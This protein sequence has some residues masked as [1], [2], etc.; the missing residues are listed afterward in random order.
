ML[1]EKGRIEY[2]TPAG[3]YFTSRLRTI[4]NES[5]RYATRFEY[6]IQ[7]CHCRQSQQ[8]RPCT[9]YG[10]YLNA[11]RL[12]EAEPCC[13]LVLITSAGVCRWRRLYSEGNSA[14]GVHSLEVDYGQTN[15]SWSNRALQSF[16]L[17]CVALICIILSVCLHKRHTLF[18]WW[19]CHCMSTGMFETYSLLYVFYLST[20]TEAP[21]PLNWASGCCAGRQEGSLL[22]WFDARMRVIK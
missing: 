4:I 15:T 19:I 9:K 20:K 21:C 1:Y 10:S 11:V 5:H 14:R 3:V 17:P 7:V 16:K 2:W 18:L 8:A 12:P 22:G 13:R 6:E